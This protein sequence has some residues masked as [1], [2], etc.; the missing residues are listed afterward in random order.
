MVSEIRIGDEV[1]LKS[2]GP[3][4]TVTRI[5]AER[6]QT[7]AQCDWL[8]QGQQHMGSVAVTSLQL[9]TAS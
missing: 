8:D 7:M 6:G 5:W 2:G 3:I 4:M 1:Q 9:A